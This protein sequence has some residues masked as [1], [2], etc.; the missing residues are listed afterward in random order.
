[1]EEAKMVTCGAIEG[2]LK[3]QGEGTKAMHLQAAAEQSGSSQ[4]LQV[5][6]STA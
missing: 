1:M 3:K 4:P 2:L 5:T 6:R